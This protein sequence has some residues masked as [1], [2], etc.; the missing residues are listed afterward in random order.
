MICYVAS[1]NPYL[2]DFAP[3]IAKVYDGLFFSVG[4]WDS[5]VLNVL[6][7]AGFLHVGWDDGIVIYLGDEIVFDQRNYPKRGKGMLFQ[8][9]SQFEKRVP[10]TIEKGRTRLS[11]NSINSHGNW[12]FS[13][14]IT[15]E[16]DLPF[17]DVR[18][19]LD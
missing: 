13:F 5:G 1:P 16:N 8:D 12:L 7:V 2:T 6:R 4:S 10:V 11:V 3:E 19:R 18:F 14:R 9:R 17:K 15:D